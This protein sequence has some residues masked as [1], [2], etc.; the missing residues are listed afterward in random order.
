MKA[1][2]LAEAHWKYVAE[3]LRKHGEDEKNIVLIGFHYCSAMV[4]GFK[5]GVEYAKR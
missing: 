4:H 5:H 2:E 1:N 3:V